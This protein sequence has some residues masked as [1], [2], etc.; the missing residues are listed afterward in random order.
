MGASATI[1]FGYLNLILY[2]SKVP[3]FG[4][5]VLMF[6]NIAKTFLHLTFFYF[7]FIVTFA[8]TFLTLLKNQVRLNHHAAIF[9]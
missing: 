6:K 8:L 3:H 1:L 7:L 5:Y 9:N 2:L 4:V